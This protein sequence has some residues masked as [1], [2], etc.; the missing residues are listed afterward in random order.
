MVLL[1]PKLGEGRR[2][3]ELP[4]LLLRVQ[5]GDALGPLRCNATLCLGRVG[6]LLPPEVS[7]PPPRPPCAPP[8]PPTSALPPGTPPSPCNSPPCTP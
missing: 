2:G 3:R 6:P 8:V 7:A 4:R 1:A 5:G